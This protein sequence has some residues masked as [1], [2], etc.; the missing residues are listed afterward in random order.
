M[1]IIHLSF[2]NLNSLAG[3]WEIDFTHP[4]YVTS[5]IFAI[6]GPTGA[7]KTTILDAICL[8][9]YGQT[10]RLA[11]ITQSENEIM[12]RLTGECFAEV[13]FATVKGTFRCHWS[14]HRSR[15][16]A[17][18]QLQSPKH[19]I[20]EVASGVIIESKLKAVAGKVEDVTGMDFD[21][22]T[23]SM[24]LAQGGFA[25]FLQARP[26]ER[27]PILEQITGTAIYSMISCKV[28][29]RTAAERGRVGELRAELDG[30]QLLSSE[31]CAALHDER[32]ELLR[33]EHALNVASRIN[34]A[35]KTWRERIAVLEGEQL[36]LG[37]ERSAL[38]MRTVATQADMEIL[39]DARRALTLGAPHAHLGAIRKLQ[40]DEQS[41]LANAGARRPQLDIL[42]QNAADA[43]TSADAGRAKIRSELIR[44]TELIRTVRTIDV[45][46]GEIQL[47]LEDIRGDNAKTG[48]Q[49]TGYRLEI[50]ERERLVAESEHALVGVITFLEEHQTDAGLMEALT[51]IEQQLKNLKSLDRQYHESRTGLEQ[52]I[53]L[54]QSAAEIQNQ[55]EAAWQTVQQSV[56]T[57]ER[58]L[59]EVR[60]T[61]ETILHGRSLSLMHSESD[62]LVARLTH[63]AGAVETA[64]RYEAGAVTITALHQRRAELELK[65]Q[66]LLHLEH[67][68]ITECDLRDQLTAQ[69]QQRIILLNRV[70][71]LEDD[72]RQLVD[73]VACPLCGAIE[74]P[75]ATGTVPQPSVALQELG[76]SLSEVKLLRE[77]LSRTSRELVVVTKEREQVEQTVAE[78][79]KHQ[80][81]DEQLS[82]TVLSQ[83]EMTAAGELWSAR[84]TKEFNV[85]QEKLHVLRR[86][87]L[88]AEQ[89]ELNVQNA[90]EALVTL[91]DEYALRDNARL[92][93]RLKCEAAVAEQTRL[94]NGSNSLRVECDAVLA[95]VGET[96]AAYGIREI[97]PGAADEILASLIIRRTAYVDTLQSKERIDNARNRSGAEAA[98][99]RALL[100]EA[101][102][103]SAGS[104]L[105]LRELSTQRD[106]LIEQR[107]ELYGE[108]TTDVEEKR[109]NELVRQAEELRESAVLEQQR[110]QAERD[111][112]I[113]QIEKLS[114]AVAARSELLSELEMA[115]SLSL[116]EAGFSDEAAFDTACIPRER[117]DLLAAMADALRAEETV[118]HTRQQDCSRALVTEREKN[119][120]DMPLD[121]ILIEFE[122]VVGQLQAAQKAI[123][124]ADHRLQLQAEQQQ[125]H[126]SRL[127]A[128]ALQ[129]SECE[130]WERLHSLI[131]SADGKKFRNFAQGLTFELMVA[132]ANR[133]LQ[134]M[135]DRYIL[136]RDSQEPLELNVIDNYQG[137]E[138]RS[139]KNLSGG[140]SFIASL[141]LSLGLSSMASRTVRVDSLFLDEGFG[142][143]DEEALETALE[144]LAALQQDGKLIGIIS[145]VPALKERIGTQIQVEAGSNG[146]SSLSGPGCRKIV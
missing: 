29:E 65:Q 24:L 59:A 91:K 119:L 12:S 145:H 129:K 78:L 18:G 58:L 41:E 52:Q 115:F 36:Q 136:I 43:Q 79:Q 33:T 121:Q 28:H 30:I 61:H 106:S 48:S 70:Q 72:R 132:H 125:R 84:F 13:T 144:T 15:K 135:S 120:T 122:A 141:A 6:T 126:Q 73:G 111:G 104:D 25:A 57:A 118:L 140:E 19:E 83:L 114:N 98:Q 94:E 143:L 44:E 46:M 88:E 82:T 90:Q 60:G 95:E 123:G 102:K 64:L 32:S 34:N 62:E 69:I 103:I 138:I 3:V 54:V 47:Q 1:K 116:A 21:R 131:G 63:L 77:E 101:E 50:A 67:S 107:R 142:T 66:E 4:E 139:T 92:A 55:A 35:A 108:R 117:F 87:I 146:R 39:A 128:I 130:R 14:Q 100:S 68:R 134:N 113:Q 75:Y 17:N 97:I 26:D 86:T 2:K 99:L 27:A 37:L 105:K 133:Q 109:M 42:W 137:G 20:V 45:K 9:L 31:E 53:A 8:A 5:G 93:A 81:R 49:I 11:R 23:R 76:E 96:V 80:D 16:Q 56:A 51:G 89:A 38:K 127:Q 124:A 10:P 112:L 40:E 7:G 71:N 85:C 22:F 74:H 110:I